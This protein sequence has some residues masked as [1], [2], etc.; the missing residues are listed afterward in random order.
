MASI[1][2]M[3]YSRIQGGKAA[4]IIDPVPG[5]QAVAVFCKSDSSGVG[6]GTT[7]SQRPGSYRAFDQSD[8]MIVGTVQ[9]QA[10]TVWIEIA[11]DETVTIHAPKGVKIETDQAVD[12]EAGQMIKLTSPQIQLNGALFMQSKSGG[13]TT[14]TLSGALNATQDVTAKGISLNSHTHPGDSGGST[15]GPQ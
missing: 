13:N 4:L 14:A 7:D 3:P 2:R 15:G 10:P 11:Q 1:P 5:D 12:I 8:G 9:N 6:V